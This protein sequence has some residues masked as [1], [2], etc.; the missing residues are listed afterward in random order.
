MKK[1]PVQPPNTFTCLLLLALTLAAGRAAA[2]DISVAPGAVD[3]AN[4]GN[5][6]LREAIHNANADAQ[7]DNSDCPA[8]LGNDTIFLAADSTYTLSSADPLDSYS[9][10]PDITSNLVVEGAGATIQRDATVACTLDGKQQP[11]QFGLLT[12][13]AGGNLTLKNLSLRHG[14]ANGRKKRGKDGGAIYVK[15]A[16]LVLDRVTVS[17]SNAYAHSGALDTA[18]STITI[19]DSSFT[20]NAAAIGGAIGNGGGSVMIVARSTIAG[21]VAFDA[22]GG[23]ANDGTV[24]IRNTTIAN[25]LNTASGGIGNAG[26]LDLVSSTV[27]G[28]ASSGALGGGGI[29]NLY[30]MRVKNSI[31]TNNG[32]GGDCVS[33]S[34]YGGT[35]DAAGNN[36]DSDGSCARDWR[37]DWP[38]CPGFRPTRPSTGPMPGWRMRRSTAMRPSVRYRRD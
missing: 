4:D 31:V 10:L 6:S 9:G 38:A 37:G 36:V 15:N 22:G 18:G 32:P 17:D 34:D 27:V 19:L 29:G 26:M 30:Q 28:N 2:T 25:N 20:S 7:V 14:C 12:V 24:T 21:N 35:F 3:V 23:I 8:G 33:I 16:T 1:L 5:C 13:P 11:G